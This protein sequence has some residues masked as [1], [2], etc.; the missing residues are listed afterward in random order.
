MKRQSKSLA[1]SLEH[2][3]SGYALAA[4]AAGVSLLA[5][6]QPAEG[7]IVYT[8]AHYLFGLYRYHPLDLNHDGTRDFHIRHRASTGEGGTFLSARPFG[9]NEICVTYRGRAAALSAGVSIGPEANWG[10]S[11]WWR[12]MV[13]HTRTHSTT[14]WSTW[15]PWA[16]VG[17][18]YLGLKFY[19]NGKAHYGWARLTVYNPYGTLTGYAYE[20]IPNAPIIAGRT[21]GPDVITVQDASLGHLARGAS[22]LSAWRQK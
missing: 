2:R 20:T 12:V 6:A 11:G 4:S 22:A 17:T 16:N 13:A 8:R 9:S 21:K 7:R 3:L 18:R 5:L 15:G 1:S 19:I 10:T 14:K